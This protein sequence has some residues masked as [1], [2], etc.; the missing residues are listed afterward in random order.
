M[1]VGCLG[2]GYE[3]WVH[4]P[5]TG[6]PRFF[7]NSMLEGVTKT[8]WWV[9][10]LLWTPALVWCLARTVLSHGFATSGLL[11]VMGVLMWQLLEYSIHRF[12]FHRIPDTYWGITA[13]FL[14]HGCHHKYPLDPSRLVFPP[15]PAAAVSA[16]IIGALHLCVPQ[17]SVVPLFTGIGIGY[18]A[19]DC[20]HYCFHHGSNVAE[21]GFMGVLRRAHLQHHFKTPDAGFGISSPL[22]DLLLKSQP[23]CLTSHPHLVLV[24]S[25]L[26]RESSA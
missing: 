6:R 18:L 24:G 19:Y 23:K 25:Q 1:Q 8:H 16:A 15:L 21:R 26:G 17:E 22:F 2:R 14:F 9:V 11:V 4:R 5:V 3:A 13:H 10:P 7:R 12:L 20:M